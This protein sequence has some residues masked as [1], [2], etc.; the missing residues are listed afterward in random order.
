MS[1]DVRHASRFVDRVRRSHDAR[2]RD[3]D[4]V[5]GD[6]R[7]DRGA[8]PTLVA[9]VGA[10]LLGIALAAVA[11]AA[12]VRAVVFDVRVLREPV[13]RAL[14]LERAHRRDER[15][16]QDRGDELHG[17]Q[18]SASR[19]RRQRET[20]GGDVAYALRMARLLLTAVLASGACGGAAPGA[21]DR[22]DVPS[23][24]GPPPP[25]RPQEPALP[26]YPLHIL[27]AL[28]FDRP[29]PLFVWATRIGAASFTVR[30]GATI[31]AEIGP[32]GG[33][34]VIGI[35][36]P[37]PASGDFAGA[38]R[39][40][41]TLERVRTPVPGTYDAMITARASLAEAGTYLLGINE[42]DVTISVLLICE[43]GECRPEC[44]GA[45]ACPDAS[46]CAREACDEGPCNSYCV[47]PNAGDQ[48]VDDP[49]SGV[50][51]PYAG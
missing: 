32:V 13:T 1:I 44:T 35:L 8:A 29:A 33:S 3:A 48:P 24:A 19:W 12:L 28:E 16:E 20:K 49:A 36:G 27:G 6:E 51:L 37:V 15:Q 34:P 46:S 30:A 38:P 17:R 43:S 10:V 41:G 9:V 5:A 11:L 45:G 2:R 47:P 25:G 40:Q 7:P 42:N 26:R 14:A 4:R 31:R 22:T 21:T 18:C 23:R 50:V 39:W